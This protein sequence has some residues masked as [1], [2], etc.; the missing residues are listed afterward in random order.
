MKAPLYLS[1]A[2]GYGQTFEK[3]VEFAH[4]EGFVGIEFIP[5]LHPNLPEE[6]DEA[7][8]K[9][10]ID[11]K[12]R[13]G[14]Q[15]TV[16]NIYMDINPTSLVPKVRQLAIALTCDVLQFALAIGAQALVIHTGY[17]F[18]PWRTKVEQM[19]MFEKV[20]K[21][22]YTILADYSVQSGVPLLLENG[23]YYLSSRNGIRQ[24]LHTGI[25]SQ[26]LI[27]MA[28]LAQNHSLGICFDIGKAYLSVKDYS[29]SGVIKYIKEVTPFL[30]EIHLSAFEGYQEVVPDV[31]T[32]LEDIDF[33]GP[34][35]L[36]CARSHIDVLRTL[37]I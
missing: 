4:D 26:D 7:R 37:F 31:L 21:E 18:G 6:M 13:Y 10:L 2:A 32:Y 30:K 22:T 14:L 17:R 9:M 16:H 19:E 20:Q 8:V 5:D 25:E 12:Q 24:P 15:Y 29:V 23:N 33:G 36:E 34:I 11:L 35:V 3:F 1:Y 28:N 27:M